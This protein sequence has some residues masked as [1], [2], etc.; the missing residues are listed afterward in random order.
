MPSRLL[1][2]DKID[3]LARL[4]LFET[5][6]Q[7]E[8]GQVASATVDTHRPAGTVLTREGQIGGVLFV[9]VEGRADVVRGGRR[10]QKLGP[11]DVV[12]ELSL[13]DGQARSASVVATTDVHVLELTY[14]DFKKLVD[15]S[16]HFVRNLL[17]ALSQRIREMDAL[18]G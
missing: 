7:R 11:G 18:A 6:S 15:K 9:L 2:Q 13:I 5:C 16:P 10:I 4:P 17:R 12:G 1:K 14:K 3:L 8:L